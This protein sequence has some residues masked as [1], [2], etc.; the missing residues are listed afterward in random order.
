MLDG[1]KFAAPGITGNIDI[2]TLP[3]VLDAKIEGLLG[4]LL[5]DKESQGG[6]L[7]Y[8]STLFF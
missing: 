4:T 7:A 2:K 5:S 1:G 3:F 8:L 6:I